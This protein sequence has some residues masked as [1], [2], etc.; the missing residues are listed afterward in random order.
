M[1][2][3]SDLFGKVAQ[4]FQSRIERLKNEDAKLEK[5]KKEILSHPCTDAGAKRVTAINARRDEIAT[6]LKN[7]AA[8]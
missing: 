2:G 1:A 5:E 7:K 4:Q 8:D 3:W 6:I